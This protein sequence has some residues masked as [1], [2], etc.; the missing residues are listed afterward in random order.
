M[1]PTLTVIGLSLGL[2]GGL[3]VAVEAITLEKIRAIRDRVFRPLHEGLI[4]PQLEWLDDGRYLSHSNSRLSRWLFD[5]PV[6]WFV[7]H[8]IFAISPVAL[9]LLLLPSSAMHFAVA[10]LERYA[11]FFASAGLWLQ[12][13]LAIGSLW[14]GLFAVVSVG[15]FVHKALIFFARVPVTALTFIEERAPSGTIG[16]IGAA[17]L[18]AGFV[19]QVAGALNSS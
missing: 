18:I 2:I 12:V 14:L 10:A 13:L 9:I 11:S 6:R 17:L 4:P 16:L 7:V 8:L 15:E 19:F 1:A 3:L 5:P